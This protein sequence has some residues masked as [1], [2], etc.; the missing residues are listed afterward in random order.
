MRDDGWS[1]A[2]VRR[3][4]DSYELEIDDKT[5]DCQ[6]WAGREGAVADLTKEQ[7]KELRERK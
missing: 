5:I 2:D 4:F 7:V 1:H 3:V 6:L